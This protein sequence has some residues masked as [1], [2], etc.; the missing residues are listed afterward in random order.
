MMKF[1]K[2]KRNVVYCG[3]CEDL[4]HQFDDETFDLVVTSPPYNVDLGN[5]KYNKD[6]Y[7][8]YDDKQEYQSYMKFMKK[9]FGDILYPKVKNGGRICINIG[10]Q[11]NGRVPVHSDFIQFMKKRYLPF[12]TIIW[13]KNNVS[14]RCAWGSYMKPSC[15]SFPSQF[16]YILIFSKWNLK[17]QEDGESD[18]TKENFVEYTKSIWNISPERNIKEHP[19]VFPEEIPRR[20]I[21][22]LTYKNMV[23]LDPFMG[24]GTTC[25][26]AKEMGRRYIGIE[27]SSNYCKLARERMNN[28]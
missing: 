18:L 16:E 22:M 13:N 20:L 15:P 14:N 4:L 24:S 25:K 26:V 5:N 1:D 12:S 3:K 7:D 27:I 9:L 21:K 11:N 23:V 6:G 17:L 10:D 2:N 8:L 28:L 19:A